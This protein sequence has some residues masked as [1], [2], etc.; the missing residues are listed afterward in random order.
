VPGQKDGG[1]ASATLAVSSSCKSFLLKSIAR[2]AV[3]NAFANHLQK[4]LAQGSAQPSPKAANGPAG[5]KVLQGASPM[6]A[7]SIA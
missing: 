1:Q 5:L 6:L 2:F 7:R 3:V 4:G